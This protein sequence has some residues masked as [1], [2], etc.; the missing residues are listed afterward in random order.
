MIDVIEGEENIHSA[1]LA[2]KD[3][4][5]TIARRIWSAEV[6]VILPFVEE[7]RQEILTHLAG[8][9]R[10]PFTTRFGEVI[11]DVRDLEIGHIESQ[12]INSGITVHPNVRRLVRRLREIRNCLSHLEPLSLELLLDAEI[13]TTIAS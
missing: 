3:F 5:G 4:K 1:S 9:L 12:L 2:L 8:V 6:G 11:S 13:N 10:V 7:R